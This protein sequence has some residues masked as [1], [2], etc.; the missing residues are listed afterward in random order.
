VERQQLEQE[1]RY[2][3]LS[4]NRGDG[5]KEVKTAR[6]Q[7]ALARD[8]FHQ[9]PGAQPEDLSIHRALEEALIAVGGKKKV[10]LPPKGPPER[11]VS[12]ILGTWAA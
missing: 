2:C 12:R 3:R 11:E 1:V 6:I 10:G 8:C 7:L 4:D 5:K 9:P